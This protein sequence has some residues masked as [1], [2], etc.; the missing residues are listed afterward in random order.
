M[1]KIGLSV[2]APEKWM[3]GWNKLYVKAL[4]DLKGEISESDLRYPIQQLFW[5]TDKIEDKEEKKDKKL[6]EFACGDGTVSCFM[7]KKGYRVKAFDAL[8]NSVKLTKDRAKL[9]KIPDKQI[10][11]E[12]GDMESYPEESEKYDVIIA[13]QCIQYLFDAAISKIEQIKRAIKPGGFFVYSG[14][15]LPHED[16]GDT[17]I[18]FVKQEEL[19]N[20]FKNWTIHTLGREEILL[21]QNPEIKRGYTWIVAQK[22]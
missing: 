9:L 21:K 1:E 22:K 3:N 12:L 8:E 6:L 4:E 11:V 7:A 16:T 14:N 18:R 19:K 2:K 15:V 13:L 17:K 20:L 10:E 5:F